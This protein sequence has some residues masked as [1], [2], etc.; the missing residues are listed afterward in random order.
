[1]PTTAAERH[2][3]HRKIVQL[4]KKQKDLDSMCINL[5][6]EGRIFIDVRLLFAAW[7]S[8]YPPTADYFCD[9]VTRAPCL[10]KRAVKI[11]QTLSE[12]QLTSPWSEG[13]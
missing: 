11:I 4:V 3:T 10:G 5:Q 6:A 2:T 1:M 7:V 8:K 9:G 13:T 12:R